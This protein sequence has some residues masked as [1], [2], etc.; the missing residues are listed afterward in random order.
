MLRSTINSLGEEA[1]TSSYLQYPWIVQSLSSLKTADFLLGK[2]LLKIKAFSPSLIFRKVSLSQELLANGMKAYLAHATLSKE[3]SEPW[4]CL[5][6]FLSSLF[7]AGM[8]RDGYM[9]AATLEWQMLQVENQQDRRTGLPDHRGIATS[10]QNTTVRKT[11]F[12]QFDTL[13]L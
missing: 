1:G 13:L 9:W 8:K 12:F 3:Y 5:P 11:N 2:Q 10:P 7:L 4:T 6:L